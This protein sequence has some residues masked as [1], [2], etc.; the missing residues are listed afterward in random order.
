M[1]IYPNWFSIQTHTNLFG[2]SIMISIK[3][4]MKQEVTRSN[5]HHVTVRVIMHLTIFPF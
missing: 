4:G 5:T 1:M 3:N 2:E